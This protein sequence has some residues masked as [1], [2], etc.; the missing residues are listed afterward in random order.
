MHQPAFAWYAGTVSLLVMSLFVLIPQADVDAWRSLI[1]FTARTS[2]AVF[3]LAY[4]ASALFRR[5][6]SAATAWLRARRQQWGLLLLTSH[7]IHLCGIVAFWWLAPDVFAQQVPVVNLYTGG[8][9]YVFLIAMGLTSHPLIRGRVGQQMWNRLHTWGMHY[10]FIS[11]L[12]ANG[13]R[14]SLDNAYAIPVVALFL[15]L[16]LRVIARRH[17]AP[18]SPRPL[19]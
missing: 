6:P 16:G 9:A 5:W 4:T 8:L 19:H 3:L 2:L 17:M 13:K 1:R 7:G 14:M 15:A 11:F 18:E 12:V 10:L